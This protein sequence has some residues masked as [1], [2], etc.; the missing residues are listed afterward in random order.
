MGAQRFSGVLKIAVTARTPLLIGG[1]TEELENGS[2]KTLLPRR[3][4][5]RGTVFIPGSGLMGS[6][7]S[8]HEALVGGCM[9]VLDLDWVP[10]HRHPPGTS[11]TDPLKLA[12]VTEVDDEGKPVEVALCDRVHWVPAHLLAQDK[13]GPIRTGDQ[14]QYLSPS[15][16][17]D[18]FPEKSVRSTPGRTVVRA[19]GEKHPGGIVPGSIVRRRGMGKIAERC[20]VVLVTDTKARSGEPVYF[21]VG[22]VGPDSGKRS[23]RKK[24]SD[25]D[26]DRKDTWDKYCRVVDK[27]DDLRPESLKKAGITGREAPPFA[28]DMEPDYADVRWPP[29]TDGDGAGD[30]NQSEVIGKRLYARPYLHVGQPVWVAVD[31]GEVT[32]IRLSQ[33]WRYEGSYS[34]GDRVGN[35]KG[36]TDPDNL[37]WS[38][39]IFGAADTEGRGDDDLAVQNSYRGHVR[40][41]DLFAIGDVRP[42]DWELAPLASPKPSA[43]QF[44]LDNKQRPKLAEHKTRPASTWGSI[45]DKGNPRNVRGRKFYWR[46]DTRAD[47][48]SGEPQRGKKRPHQSESMSSRVELIPA[49]TRFEGRITFDNLSA[50]DYGSLLAALAP[51][52]LG[53]VGQDGWDDTVTSV[54]GGKPFGFGSVQVE[55]TEDTV[56]TARGRY[57]GDDADATPTRKEAVR[58]FLTA[59]PHE[60][61]QNWTALRHALAFGFVDDADVWYPAGDGRRG[62]EDYDKSFEFFA[63]TNGLKF[64]EGRPEQ[65]LVPLPDAS[66][67]KRKQK[68]STPR[69]SAR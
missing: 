36:C 37:C 59:A 62:D 14:V 66:E 68:L 13:G 9:R 19:H 50:E 53:T 4:A 1:F 51:R 48:A 40:I 24:E 45:A 64:S 49:G 11:E 67:G 6:V 15:G 16:E 23:L 57:L 26:P 69:R 52:M 42:I 56:Q 21:A 63:R 10:V 55:V 39:R 30:G 28:R 22:S 33:L 61:R 20:K 43:G 25:K 35:A 34:V 17:E 5:P 41:D 32:E 7:R 38:C 44:Y 46:T 58:A 2:K 8:A 18:E 60:A 3:K 29:R 27:A 31:D 12:V 47:P 54:G 65:P